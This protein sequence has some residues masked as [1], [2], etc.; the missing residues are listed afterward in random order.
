MGIMVLGRICITKRTSWFFVAWVIRRNIL[1]QLM[2]EHFGS[3]RSFWGKA[4]LARGEQEQQ[5]PMRN[6]ALCSY[7]I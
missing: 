7:A 3:E 1:V 5:L 2:M 6:M 4:G